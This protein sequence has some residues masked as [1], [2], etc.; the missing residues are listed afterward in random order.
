MREGLKAEEKERLWLREGRL[1]SSSLSSSSRSRSIVLQIPSARLQSYNP[2]YLHL[3]L[4]TELSLTT[5]SVV[6]L[7]SLSPSHAR[8]T[9]YSD[10]PQFLRLGQHHLLP[11]RSLAPGQSTASSPSSDSSLTALSRLSQVEYALE[12][13]KQ[14]SASVG[15]RSKTHVLLLALK[16][17]PFLQPLSPTWD[18]SAHPSLVLHPTALDGRA[19]FVP[20][21]AHPHRRP[22][23]YRH[24]W[25]H[26]GC[27]CFVVCRSLA[28]SGAARPSGADDVV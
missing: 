6:T 15:L 17:S 7:S 10:A 9:S 11:R 18:A 22:H 19:R 8:L 21:E 23:R 24:R 25:T 5:L 28:L 12:A 3:A 27:S 20:K 1:P 14:G 26:L 13:V 4:A 2:T 16:V